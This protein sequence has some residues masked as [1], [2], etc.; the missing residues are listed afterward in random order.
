VARS[1]LYP[2][3]DTEALSPQERMLER[4]YDQ[5]DRP[6]NRITPS[7]FF[8][9]P[10][11][12]QFLETQYGN[13]A[14]NVPPGSQIINQTPF[15]VEY[16]DAEGFT[17]VLTRKP[18]SQGQVTETTNRPA[19]PTNAAQQQQQD[20]AQ[21]IQKQLQQSFGQP[22]T[23]AELDPQTYAALKAQ[24]DAE[25]AAINQQAGDLEGQLL[26]RLFGQGVNRS[27]IATNAG[28]RF[29][30]QVGLVQQQ[31]RSDAANRELSIRNLLT[32]LGQQQRAN[33]QGTLAGLYS[34][35]TGQGTQR[36][37]AGAGLDLDLKKLLES[38]RQ[39]NAGN[40][41][42]ALRTQQQQEQLD[43]QRGPLAK[44]LGISQVVSNFARAA[45][46]GI[47]AY[48]ALRK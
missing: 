13:I 20:F 48:D 25:Q 11:Y 9:S 12:G 42:D 47:S 46:G 39:F 24:S 23:L 29:A 27:S 31:Q 43:L 30:Q 33:E 7:Q 45:G 2:G 14:D 34:N 8:Q 38:Q 44:A 3:R 35:L 40:Y 15:K 22:T 10:E 16:R 21:S 32:T 41:L 1:Y 37:I 6:G 36:D 4:L 26:A 19:I 17:H 18:D 5:L 28:A